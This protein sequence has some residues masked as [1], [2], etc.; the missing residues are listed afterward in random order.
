MY[1]TTTAGR[2]IYVLHAD[3]GTLVRTFDLDAL[4]SEDP[5]ASISGGLVA[6]QNKLYRVDTSTRRTV[7]RLVFPFF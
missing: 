1:S 5:L 4:D 2:T 7:Y 6:V 3:T